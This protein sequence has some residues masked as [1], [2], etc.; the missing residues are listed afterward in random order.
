MPRYWTIVF[1]V[2]LLL[3]ALEPVDGLTWFLDMVPAGIVFVALLLTQRQFILTPLCYALLLVLCLLILEGAHFTFAREPLFEAIKHWLGAARN[4]FDRLAHL[5]QGLVP[6]LVFR[7]ILVRREVVRDR[8]WLPWLVVALTLAL[9]AAYELVEWVAALVLGSRGEHFLATQGDTF[10]AQTDMALALVGASLGLRLFSR[11][12][13][14]QMA[15]LVSSSGGSLSPIR[16]LPHTRR[17]RGSS[18]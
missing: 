17:S 6:A 8:V 11:L 4:D 2:A 12:H 14:R 7:E 15:H 9:S 10:D 3:S 1:P 18:H 5:L 13:D 16:R